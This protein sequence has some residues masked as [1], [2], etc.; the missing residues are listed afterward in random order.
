MF[1]IFG[2]FKA[3]ATLTT[4]IRD[5]KTAEKIL[6]P[7]EAELIAERQ[8]LKNSVKK[9]QPTQTQIVYSEKKSSLGQLTA[10]RN[11]SYCQRY[12]HN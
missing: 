6:Q 8:R 2:E 7:S 10:T 3:N 11:S 1:L 5:R 12:R 9:L 4:E